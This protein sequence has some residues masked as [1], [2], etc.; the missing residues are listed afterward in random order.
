MAVEAVMPIFR[1][2]VDAAEQHILRMHS[3]DFGTVDAPS[4]AGASPYMAD[5]VRH[6]SHCR[7]NPPC[8]SK[9]FPQWGSTQP[10][11]DLHCLRCMMRGSGIL[12]DGSQ[13]RCVE[14]SGAAANASMVVP[15]EPSNFGGRKAAIYQFESD[16]L[17]MLIPAYMKES[18]RIMPLNARYA[19]APQ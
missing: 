6:I 5:L 10:W 18:V 15:W 14:R 13:A 11:C 16:F 3:Q 9:A 12:S 17:L 19:Q 7:C 2:A 8:S 1:A 4:V